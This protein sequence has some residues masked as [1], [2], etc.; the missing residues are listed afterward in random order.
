MPKLERGQPEAMAMI[1]IA[2]AAACGAQHFG[3]IV[4]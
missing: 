2:D 3:G 4:H 1:A